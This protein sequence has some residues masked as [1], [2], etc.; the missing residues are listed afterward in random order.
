M[1][2]ATH[3]MKYMKRYFL[4]FT[5]FTLFAFG[6][7]SREK[8][9][10]EK[11]ISDYFEAMGGESKW[12]DLKSRKAKE[13]YLV[14]SSGMI[15]SVSQTIPFVEFYQFPN[16]YLTSHVKDMNLNLVV[17]TSDCAWIYFGR[18]ESIFFRGKEYIRDQEKYPRI[19]ALEFLNFPI[20]GEVNMEGEHYKIDFID[21]YDGRIVSVYFNQQTFLIE[22][23]SYYAGQVLQE[24]ILSEYRTKNGFT[25]PYRLDNFVDGK[26]YKTIVT[27]DIIY[28]SELSLLIF[29]PPV[30]CQ[31]SENLEKLE[32]PLPNIY[33]Y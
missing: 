25:E 17:N 23:Y 1:R 27:E 13:K 7:Q 22:K 18:S 9:T 6:F 33:T 20:K 29:E 24:N 2:W 16:S 31:A 12:I 5:Y 26:K 28:N 32:K 30:P 15:E 4:L 8:L 19:E 3:L 11:I 21:N 14:Y 10:A